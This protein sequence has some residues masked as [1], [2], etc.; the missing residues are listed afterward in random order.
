MTNRW[1]ES[2]RV[3]EGAVPELAIDTTAPAVDLPG[4]VDCNGVAPSAGQQPH[5]GVPQAAHL[6]RLV[7]V[8]RRPD[9]Q[10]PKLRAGTDMSDNNCF[11]PLACNLHN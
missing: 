4:L 5:G 1:W 9:A 2:S 7:A 10:L 11:S 8:R 6:H 3:L